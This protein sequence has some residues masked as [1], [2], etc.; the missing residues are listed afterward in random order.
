MTARRPGVP[1]SS[2]GAPQ[3]LG[4]STDPAGRPSDLRDEGTEPP[5]NAAHCALYSNAQTVAPN[6]TGVRC[7]AERAAPIQNVRQE[8]SSVAPGRGHPAAVLLLSP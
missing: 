8:R 5:A 3:M 4:R 7:G 6:R 1:Q 2:A